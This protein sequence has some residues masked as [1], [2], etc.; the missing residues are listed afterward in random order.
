MS[1]S[2]CVHTCMWI[3]GYLGGWMCTAGVPGIN[4]QPCAYHLDKTCLGRRGME[5]DGGRGKRADWYLGRLPVYS[6]TL[7]TGRG[8]ADHDEVRPIAF[9]VVRAKLRYTGENPCR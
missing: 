4:N 1:E 8:G 7:C 9:R 2:V 3:Y 5:M 6:S